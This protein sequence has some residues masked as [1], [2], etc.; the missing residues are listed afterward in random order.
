M[1]RMHRIAPPAFFLLPPSSFILCTLSSRCA[2][3]C[4]SRD[5]MGIEPGY[6]RIA[7]RPPLSASGGVS[8][9]ELMVVLAIISVLASI[10]LVNGLWAKERAKEAV[11]LAN[12]RVELTTTTAAGTRE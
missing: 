12:D 5:V 8:L 4:V 2:R 1:S 3:T 10:Q 7:R 6:S 11:G 9:V